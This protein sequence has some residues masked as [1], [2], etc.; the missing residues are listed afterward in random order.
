MDEVLEY[1]R[2]GT[3]RKFQDIENRNGFEESD[4]YK[5]DS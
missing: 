3:F 5:K 1:S 4:H 2:K